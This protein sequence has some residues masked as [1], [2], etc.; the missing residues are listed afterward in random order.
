MNAANLLSGE[1]WNS[2]G[3]P[4]RSWFSISVEA[5][6]AVDCGKCSNLFSQNSSL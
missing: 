2:A 1:K 6:I 3:W 5:L 4:A